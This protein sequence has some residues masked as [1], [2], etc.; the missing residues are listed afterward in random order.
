[1]TGSS[2]A[3]QNKRAL[4]IVLEGLDWPGLVR[5]LDQGMLPALTAL[6]RRGTIVPVRAPPTERGRMA[7][8]ALA[9]GLPPEAHGLV[10]PLE[11]WAGGLRPVG[12]TSWATPPLW[13]RLAAAGHPVAVAGWPATAPATAWRARV[14]DDR[15]AQP[16][17]RSWNN[18][19]LPLDVCDRALREDVR[20]LRMHPADVTGAMLA[21]FVPDLMSVD[22]TRD[23]RLIELALAVAA[24][25]T[26]AAATERLAADRP[27]AL[28][29]YQPLIAD[30]TRRFDRAVHP[31]A[32]VVDQAW[33]LADAIV[34]RAVAAMG[35]GAAVMV[36]SAG[37]PG[38]VGAAI[39][40]ADGLPAGARHPGIDR[41]DIAP[42]F[43]ALLGRAAP[44]LPGRSL[45]TATGVSLPSA[46]MP[47]HDAV[48]S[49]AAIAALAAQGYPPV[50]SRSGE[51]AAHQRAALAE[52]LIGRDLSAAARFAD[53][54]LTIDPESRLA[55]R[56][57]A[58]VHLA[59][60]EAAPLP[61]IADAIARTAPDDPAAALIRG[62]HCVMVGR[63]S[64]ARAWLGRAEASGLRDMMLRVGAAWLAARSW[65][66][67]ERVA[68]AILASFPDDP[69]ASIGLAM[70]L[71]GAR[72]PLE[73][74]AVLREQLTRDA[75]NVVALTQLRSVLNDTGRTREAAAITTTL[76]GLSGTAAG[77]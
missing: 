46:A 74:E 60:G 66:D 6:A 4:L 17:G 19:A 50:P 26:V 51:W 32:A 9:T 75:G 22:Q 27:A 11:P 42:T 56:V 64:A 13:E 34:A 61:D 63:V 23:Q 58:L 35:E 29:V 40:A 31:Y 16:S 20:D 14:I 76:D 67:A 59:A 45:V 39:M 15:L 30:V 52:Q 25:S 5:R 73:A 12:H 68:R 57:R 55:L 36:V 28:F 43:A 37:L 54:A 3:L 10:V 53:A 70:A 38:R 77:R 41:L 72:R 21:P 69:D 44:D 1:M 24:G 2:H 18:W 7:I 47:A 65:G 48:A 8:G 71:A 49:E 33:V 62:V